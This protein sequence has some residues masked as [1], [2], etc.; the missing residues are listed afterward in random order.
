MHHRCLTRPG[1]SPTNTGRGRVG[2]PSA[3]LIDPIALRAYRH[4]MDGAA[5]GHGDHGSHSLDFRSPI[6]GD[7]Q[8]PPERGLSL[9]ELASLALLCAVTLVVAITRDAWGFVWPSA[10][11]LVLII[12]VSLAHWR[13]RRRL[14]SEHG[15]SGTAV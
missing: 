7:P 3:G 8:T 13:V 1:R 4:G 15:E 2:S 14:R 10:A 6:P 5:G 11:A 9:R 12:G